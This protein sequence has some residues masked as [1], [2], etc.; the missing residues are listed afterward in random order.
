MIEVTG[1]MDMWV[2]IKAQKSA[3]P[4]THDLQRQRKVEEVHS[5]C[6][7]RQQIVVT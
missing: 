7:V 5:S 6:Q 2:T 3:W 1:V 4:L